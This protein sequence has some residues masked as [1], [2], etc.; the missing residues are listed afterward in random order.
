LIVLSNLVF[1][2]FYFHVNFKKANL[3]KELHL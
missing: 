1:I 3:I 2:L